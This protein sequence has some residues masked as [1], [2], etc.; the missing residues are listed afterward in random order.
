MSRLILLFSILALSSTLEAA[1]KCKE[2]STTQMAKIVC[3]SAKAAGPQ[4][5]A[6]DWVIAC[7]KGGE[8]TTR[9]VRSAGTTI[10][11]V[12]KKAGGHAFD[13]LKEMGA[14]VADPVGKLN[15]IRHNFS[16]YGPV[17]ARY[18]GNNIKKALSAAAQIDARKAASTFVSGTQNLFT[19][20]VSDTG[21][22]I[23]LTT[24]AGNTFACAPPALQQQMMCQFIG[25][26]SVSY[27]KGAGPISA[28]TRATQIATKAKAMAA[29]AKRV[30]GGDAVI[31]AGAKKKLV[32]STKET[33]LRKSPDGTAVVRSVSETG[34]EK[35]Y[36]DEIVTTPANKQV[37]ERS[38]IIR[39]AK[40]LAIDS[41]FEAGAKFAQMSAHS[42]QGGH[43]VS[44]DLNYL[45]KVNYFPGGTTT[46]NDYI[47]RVGE[48]IRSEVRDPTTT[49]FKNGG[50]E[51]VAVLPTKNPEDVQRISQRIAD[52]IFN[53]PELN[54][55]F[56]D[57]RT[58]RAAAIPRGT[59]PTADQ[60]TPLQSIS[61][62]RP[63]VSVGATR[64]VAA[65]TAEE[66]WAQALMR[67]DEA[68]A[69]YK[70]DLRILH[71]TYDGKQGLA[72][73]TSTARPNP[74]V[75]PPMPLPN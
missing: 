12:G 26:A 58:K 70:N 60:L 72:G 61:N 20:L 41:N 19:K 48:I 55:I 28:A 3:E 46:G 73:S 18:Y 43:L 56:K 9:A 11:R 13:F 69:K 71:G 24:L 62:L 53:D 44:F 40:S 23:R 57:A 2:P 67:A 68:G 38:E 5:S 37:I 54:Q 30:R 1:P 49:V 35:I 27:I 66:T 33:V 52:R 21:E 25:E 4:R 16:T 74:R 17:A 10:V 51:L 47:K 6:K 42:N 22:L 7:G 34:R 75:L 31:V 36:L 39:D 50:D 15:G 64:I 65:D 45:G 59:T 63:S 29:A 14:T 32:A 8:S